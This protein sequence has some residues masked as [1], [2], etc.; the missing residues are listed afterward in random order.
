M[1]SNSSGPR[2]LDAAFV[3]VWQKNKRENR[4]THG[5]IRRIREISGTQ[6]MI[7]TWLLTVETAL[8]D[9]WESR[10]RR[11]A[12]DRARLGNAWRLL[13]AVSPALSGYD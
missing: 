6:S 8:Q 12:K 4:F 13:T 5:L 7:L 10:T 9:D 2:S 3:M 11:F 1:F